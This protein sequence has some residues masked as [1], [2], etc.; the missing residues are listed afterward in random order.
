MSNKDLDKIKNAC[1]LIEANGEQ[2]TGYLVAANLIVTCH[3]VVA[4]VADNDEEINVNFEH[5]E[6]VGRVIKRDV[7]NDCALIELTEP[8][9]ISEI[10]P[11][12]I[13]QNECNCDDEWKAYG[14]PASIGGVGH[15]LKGEIRDTQAQA[16]YDEKGIKSIAL[17]SHDIAAGQGAL[18]HGF[19][20]TPVLVR[21]MVIGHLKK[22]IEDDLTNRAEMGTLYASPAKVILSLLTENLLTENFK[23]KKVLKPQPPGRSYD[24]DW[25][26]NSSD[27]E[28]NA[29]NHLNSSGSPVSI[30]GIKRSGKTAFLEHLLQII[31]SD[32]SINN[33]I[34]RINFGNFDEEDE[35]SLGSFLKQ[36]AYKM[37]DKLFGSQEDAIEVVDNLWKPKLGVKSSIDNIMERYILDKVEGI[38]ILAIDDADEIWKLDFKDAIFGM[39]RSWVQNS[40]EKWQK[41][42]LI[43]AVSTEPTKLIQDANQSPFN[44]SVPIYLKD[45][46]A[47][48]LQL[49]SEKYGLDWGASEIKELMAQIGGHP[50]LARLIMY[51]IAIHTEPR[52]TIS[53]ILKQK[54]IFDTYLNGFKYWLNDTEMKLELSRYEDGG[55]HEPLNINTCKLLHKMGFLTKK[56]QDNKDYYHLRYPIYRQLIR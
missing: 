56:E 35:S 29:L 3:H 2:G 1:A 28:K 26:I 54:D 19:S 25:Y 6:Y 21:G 9:N 24:P 14:F 44:L 34:V 38:L 7:K 11:L 15:L 50:Y 45:L 17:Y 4:S 16:P 20:G 22:I 23:K 49:L 10:E 40:G 32:K 5:R 18:A 31:K 41:F 39:L 53:N 37:V 55:L 36:L 42:R 13:S 30:Y 12:R 8:V 47:D 46:D 43:L 52:P 51:K 33:N 48:Q 27:E